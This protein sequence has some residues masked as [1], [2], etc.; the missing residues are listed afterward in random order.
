MR[1]LSV[2]RMAATRPVPVIIVAAYW[3][4][5]IRPAV[6]VLVAGTI[7]AVAGQAMRIW[8][9]GHIVKDAAIAVTGPFAYTRH[10]LYLGSTVIGIG[11]CVAS[12]IWWSYLLIVAVFGLFYI[13]TA[14]YE[15][16]WLRTTYGDLYQRYRAAVPGIGIRMS[17]YQSSD[18]GPTVD[19][20]RVFSWQ[21]MIGNRE[22]YTAVATVLLLAT[23]WAKLPFA[24]GGS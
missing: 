23:L 15:E 24:G 14:L 13:P 19:P 18:A 16:Q 6:G 17:R 5:P 3:L 11:F 10:P 22:H 7:L 8:A 9:A 2:Y 1:F 21:R 20:N 4:L 12:G